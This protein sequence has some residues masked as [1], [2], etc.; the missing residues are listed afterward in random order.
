MVDWI[1]KLSGWTPYYKSVL[2]LLTTLNITILCRSTGCDGISPKMLNIATASSVA[3]L[4]SKL[5]NL[6]VSITTGKFPKEWKLA[7]VVQVP[8]GSNRNSLAVYRPISILPVV[9]KIIERH[10]KD[11]IYILDHLSK[12][13]S[14]FTLPVGI[15]DTPLYLFQLLLE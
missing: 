3:L 11:I 6:T 14:H 5:I 10:V 9:T 2:D 7:R 15:Y 1:C 8:K 4:L 12:T 13:C